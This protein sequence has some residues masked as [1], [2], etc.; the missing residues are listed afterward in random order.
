MSNNAGTPWP[1]WVRCLVLAAGLAASAAAGY[2]AALV[3]TLVA[4]ILGAAPSGLVGESTPRQPWVT[5]V[6]VAVGLSVFGLGVWL[7][8]KAFRRHREQHD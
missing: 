3:S 6:V 1:T 8:V 7:S 2:L 4:V 5:P